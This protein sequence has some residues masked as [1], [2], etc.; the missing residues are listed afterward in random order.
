[1]KPVPSMAAKCTCGENQ[2]QGAV[3]LIHDPDAENWSYD[4]CLRYRS[5]P[6]TGDV[7]PRDVRRIGVNFGAPGWCVSPEGAV[8]LHY[9]LTGKIRLLEKS[10]TVTGKVEY[11]YRPS[12][13]LRGDGLKWVAASGVKGIENVSLVLNPQKKDARCTVRLHFAEPEN[14]KPGERVFDVAVNGKVV[15]KDFDVAREAGGPDSSLVREIK[16][17]GIDGRLVVEFKPAKDSRY[18]PVVSGMEIVQDTN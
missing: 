17:V 14:A 15:L 8:W 4:D 5:P 9:P 10:L 13:R 11:Y 16:D 7:L 12:S 18:P 6:W 2:V 1:M 3:A